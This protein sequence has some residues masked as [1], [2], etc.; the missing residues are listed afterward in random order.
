MEGILVHSL[1]AE[2]LNEPRYMQIA[3]PVTLDVV[4]LLTPFLLAPNWAFRKTSDRPLVFFEVAV[5]MVHLPVEQVVFVVD[6]KMHTERDDMWAVDEEEY[7]TVEKA[8][9]F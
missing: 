3:V 1:N 4:V 8:C 7:H 5:I 9:E 2:C 6:E